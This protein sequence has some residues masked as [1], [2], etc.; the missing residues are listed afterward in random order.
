MVGVNAE[1]GC[2]KGKKTEGEF[3]KEMKNVSADGLLRIFQ[4]FELKIDIRIYVHTEA[5]KNPISK[6]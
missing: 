4:L 1:V 6:V 2:A 3:A 5:P